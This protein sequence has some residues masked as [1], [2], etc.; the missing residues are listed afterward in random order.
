[1]LTDHRAILRDGSSDR[2]TTQKKRRTM[3][4]TKT[5]TGT[6]HF[7]SLRAAVRYYATYGYSVGDVVKK[8]SE[9]A[10]CLGRPRLKA[11]QALGINAEGRYTIEEA[12]R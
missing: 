12:S 1:M 6:A 4:T 7:L 5:T 9:G 2:L 3:K 11:G 8:L 10:I